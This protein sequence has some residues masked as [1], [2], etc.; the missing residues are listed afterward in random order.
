[1]VVERYTHERAMQIEADMRARGMAPVHGQQRRIDILRAAGLP[2]VCKP[3]AV[4]GGFENNVYTWVEAA[5]ILKHPALC[6]HEREA[7]LKRGGGRE[8]WTI[9]RRRAYWASCV[10]ALALGAQGVGED[11]CARGTGTHG[12][13]MEDT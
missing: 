6:W 10:T 7:I 12:F 8:P 3:R 9:A 11:H 1:M 2:L 13:G 4:A 5:M